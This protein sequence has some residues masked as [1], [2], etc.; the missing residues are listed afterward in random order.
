M[1]F[2]AAG[3]MS[4]L[5]SV[6]GRPDHDGPDLV[7]LIVGAISLPS[8]LRE[9]D[10]GSRDT[11]L[12]TTAAAICGAVYGNGLERR[13]VPILAKGDQPD[14]VERLLGQPSTAGTRKNH[15]RGPDPCV[16]LYSYPTF[17]LTIGFVDDRVAYFSLDMNDFVIPGC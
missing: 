6:T 8:V 7:P 14:D 15:G 4:I 11:L 5:R 13:G 10:S 9:Q 16:W 17:T 12:I 2:L 3:R 1:A